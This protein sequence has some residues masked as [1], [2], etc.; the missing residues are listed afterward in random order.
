[1]D[2]TENRK[3][4]RSSPVNEAQLLMEHY[5]KSI[6]DVGSEAGNEKIIQ[7][8]KEMNRRRGQSIWTD[9]PVLKPEKSVWL[10]NEPTAE[11]VS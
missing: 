10:D 2:N 9:E 1:M 5:T 7:K 11:K 6:D 4:R 3:N 8:I